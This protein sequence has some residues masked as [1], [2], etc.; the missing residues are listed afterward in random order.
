MPVSQLTLCLIF[1]RA[2]HPNGPNEINTR[3]S[4]RTRR[5]HNTF[6]KSNPRTTSTSILYLPPVVFSSKMTDIPF[7]VDRLCWQ[8]SQGCETQLHNIC[9]NCLRYVISS[10]ALQSQ[11][12]YLANHLQLPRSLSHILSILPQ[13][14]SPF[15]LTRYQP[16]CRRMRLYRIDC[17][18]W[19]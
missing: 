3:T 14:C 2:Q 1:D 11:I 13:T 5:E 9:C 4:L 19:C 16:L 7:V 17:S 18:F 15:I 6:P 12:P 8:L 10:Q